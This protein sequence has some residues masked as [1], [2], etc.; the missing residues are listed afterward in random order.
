M[1]KIVLVQKDT[2]M[3]TE[4]VAAVIGIILSFSFLRS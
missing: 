4:L 2:M 3:S 1:N